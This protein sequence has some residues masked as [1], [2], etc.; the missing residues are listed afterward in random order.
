MMERLR[1]LFQEN[2]AIREVIANILNRQDMDD[3]QRVELI[4][5]ILAAEEI[6]EQN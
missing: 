6:K 4:L 5:E 3:S 2:P 1:K